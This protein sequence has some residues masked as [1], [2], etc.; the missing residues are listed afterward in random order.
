MS[1]NIILFDDAVVKKQLLPFTF[2]RPVSEIRCG[3]LTIREKWEKYLVGKASYITDAYLAKKYPVVTE[4]ENILIKANLLPDPEVAAAI[5]NLKTSE[6]LVAADEWLAANVSANDLRIFSQSFSLPSETTVQYEKGLSRIQRL[7]DIFTLNGEEIKK[8]FKVITAG[9]LTDRVSENNRLVNHTDIF[10]EEGTDIEFSILNA[11]EGPIYIGKNVQIMEGAMIR[12]PFAAGEGAV[13]KMGAKIYG[14][15]TIGPFCKV[16]GEINN[17]VMFS[18]SN[19]AHDGYLGN[20]VIGEWCNLGADTNNS[21]LKNDY[22]EVKLWSY[23]GNSFV[24][25]GLQ[26]CGLMMG[27]HSKCG[28]NTMFNTGTMVGVFCNIFG[29]GFPRNF[30]PSYSWGGANGFT[31]YKFDKA[32]KVAKLVLDRRHLELTNED[33]EILKYVYDSKER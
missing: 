15:T 27:D 16:G 13:I 11:R 10:I 3:I 20:A 9:R 8:D 21:N 24:G 32:I 1:K 22:S 7:W 5:M 18:Q 6:V 26:F 28:I 4:P 23:A 25:T 33:V 2:T 12:G 30:I 14:G 31:E 29:A 19:K 17:A